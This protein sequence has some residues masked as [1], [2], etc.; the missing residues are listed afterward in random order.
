MV[1]LLTLLHSN[2]AKL[3]AL[4]QQVQN[5]DTTLLLLSLLSELL[6]YSK[7]SAIHDHLLQFPE[8]AI[9]N[10]NPRI[11]F[12]GV[13]TM[14]L[15]ALGGEKYAR[16]KIALLFQPVFYFYLLFIRFS[17]WMKMVQKLKLNML[18]YKEFL[19]YC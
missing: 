11:K 17:Y 9:N 8:I 4:P 16:D 15:W 10:E 5:E 13:K 12:M 3:L 14:A 7:T 1:E 19:I 2:E 18:L 6:Q